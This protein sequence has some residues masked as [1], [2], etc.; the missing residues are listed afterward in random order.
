MAYVLFGLG[1]CIQHHGGVLQWRSIFYYFFGFCVQGL[2]HQAPMD[3]ASLIYPKHFAD[4]F[5]VR[6]GAKGV[7]STF[8]LIA[9]GFDGSKDANASYWYDAGLDDGMASILLD[10]GGG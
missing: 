2:S 6:L 7:G 4:G 5:H 10:A 8:F 3:S 9:N 1:K